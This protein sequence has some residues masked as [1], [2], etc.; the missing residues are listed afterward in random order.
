MPHVS[1]G[2]LNTPLL[3]YGGRVAGIFFVKF[4]E[5]LMPSK[6]QN[7]LGGLLSLCTANPC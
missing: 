6:A 1:G 5:E 7:A 2:L 4:G 3:H